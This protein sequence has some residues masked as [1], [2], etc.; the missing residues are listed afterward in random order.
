MIDLGYHREGLEESEV[1]LFNPLT[2]SN[3][4]IDFTPAGRY[5]T[6]DQA[7]MENLVNSV[8]GEVEDE[9]KEHFGKDVKVT[10]APPKGCPEGSPFRRQE[11]QH[12]QGQGTDAG[13]GLA[14]RLYRTLPD[15]HSLPGHRGGC[16]E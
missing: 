16:R 3:L 10:P 14:L 9:V 7:K 1:F 6:F 12:L 11:I 2:Q 4:Q 5:A 13:A 15:F 8:T